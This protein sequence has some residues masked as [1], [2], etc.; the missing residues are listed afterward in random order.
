M[1]TVHF[2]AQVSPEQLLEAL[3][4]LPSPEFERLL[5]GALKLRERRPQLSRPEPR[6][7][8]LV[9]QAIALL[10]AELS[11][12]S[13]ALRA[14][15]RAGQITAAEHEQLLAVIDEIEGRNVKRLEALV[16]LA[17]LRQQSLRAVMDDLGLKPPVDEDE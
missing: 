4:Q 5:A 7:A 17:R 15:M 6:E 11:A 13:R 3:R 9:A 16:E 8:G 10:P 2:E 1:A 14:K 12:Q